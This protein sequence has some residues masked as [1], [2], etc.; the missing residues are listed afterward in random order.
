MTFTYEVSDGQGGT[1]TATGTITVEGTNDGPVAADEA[2]TATEDGGAVTGQLD[3]TDIDGDSLTYTQTGDE[4]PGLTINA[5][6]SYSFDP[7]EGYQD[8][9]VG[10]TAEVTFTYEVSDGQGGT[11]TATGTITVEGT[12]DGPVASDDTLG[13]LEDRD[14]TFSADDLLA[15]DTDADGD[16]MT[17]TSFDQPDHGTITDNGDGTYTFT[18]DEDWSGDTSFGYTVSDGEGGTSTATA[19]VSVEA[20]ADAPDLSVAV[21][22]PT[23]I[24]DG[25]QHSGDE[26]SGSGRGHGG[27]SG[28][29]SGRGHGGGS[30]S[31]SGSGSGRG[32]GGGSGSGSGRG[33]GHGSGSGSGRGHGGGSGS[34]RGGGS[35]DDGGTDGGGELVYPLDITA[36]VN[37]SSESLVVTIDGVPD[38]AS[39]SDPAVYDE[40]SGTWSVDGSADMSGLTMTVP[41][42]AGDFLLNVNATSTDTNGDTFTTSRVIEIDVDD[43]GEFEFGTAGTDGD[44]TMT[45]T[46]GADTLLGG[47]GN[48]SLDAG[49]GDDIM[50]GGAGDDTFE[51][52]AGDDMAFGDGGNDLFIFGAGDGSDYFDGGDGWTDTISM[53][54]VDGGPGGDSGW[55]LQVDD[56][57]AFTQTEDGIDFEGDASGTI[58]LS[59]GSELTFDGVDKIEW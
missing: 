8:L 50:V 43:D 11:S 48:D 14:I 46:D 17:I 21:G 45:G 2:V 58:Q 35:G 42:D 3:A 16:T 41:E 26:G 12:N 9:G 36:D 1:S 37:D 54:G 57:A 20:V 6:G 22:E 7:G 29:G 33:W 34:G 10:E 44:D 25:D 55:T 23:Y 56:D 13:G 51:G 52:G 31:G 47:D 39:L 40:S 28:S 15:N 53:E 24:D 4:V 32:H 49:A 30:G 27:G 19:S 59:D 5:D 38:G 18:P